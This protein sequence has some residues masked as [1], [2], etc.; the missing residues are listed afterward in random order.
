[1][2]NLTLAK[3]KDKKSFIWVQSHLGSSKRLE[4][5][6]IWS[7]LIILKIWQINWGY[8]LCHLSCYTF[9]YLKMKN[10]MNKCWW[11]KKVQGLQAQFTKTYFSKEFLVQGLTY[12]YNGTEMKLHMMLSDKAWYITFRGLVNRYSDPWKQVLPWQEVRWSIQT[13]ITNDLT[14]FLCLTSF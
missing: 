7:W 12:S 2:V 4:L 5:R 11:L 8:F 6:A 9:V 14:I 13:T 3:E 1:M 10:W